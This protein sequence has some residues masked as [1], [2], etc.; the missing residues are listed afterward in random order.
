MQFD[1]EPDIFKLFPGLHLVLAL[2]GPLD[3]RKH[4]GEVEKYWKEAWNQAGRLDLQNAQ[5]HPRVKTWREQFQQMG[6]SAKKFP[7]SIEALLRRALKGG[8]PFQINQVVDF[9]NAVSLKHVVA[10][11]AFDLDSLEAGIELR[12]TRTGDHFTALDQESPLMQDPGEVAYTSGSTVLTRHFMWRQSRLGLVQESSSN[13]FVIS[14]VPGIA[15]LEGAVAV[16]DELRNGLQTFFG[17]HAETCI[18]NQ[19]LTSFAW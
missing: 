6:V 10:L 3:N 19:S 9:Y 17:V 8:E 2:P 11:G 15:G 13:V 16:E 14:E 4:G 1:V 5:S 7:T 18:L 12:R